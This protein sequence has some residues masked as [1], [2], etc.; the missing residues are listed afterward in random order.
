[1]INKSSI[2]RVDWRAL[3]SSLARAR[4]IDG[5][6]E[7][8]IYALNSDKTVKAIVGDLPAR[9]RETFILTPKVYISTRTTRKIRRCNDKVD[10]DRVMSINHRILEDRKDRKTLKPDAE[11]QFAHGGCLMT[12]NVMMG[13]VKRKG[14]RKKAKSN[15]KLAKHRERE[16]EKWR[17]SF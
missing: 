4:I 5:L 8:G 6:E 17:V 16:T 15:E 10:R 11:S 2:V 3:E 9:K 13:I 14:R 12:N 1:M 7:T